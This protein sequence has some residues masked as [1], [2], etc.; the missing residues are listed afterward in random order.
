MTRITKVRAAMN[1][2]N[3]KAYKGAREYRVWKDE[4]GWRAGEAYGERVFVFRSK[5]GAVAAEKYGAAN[6]FADG[7]SI[8]LMGKRAESD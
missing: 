2:A 5:R 4:D 1:R 7:L 3:A 8:L 6:Y